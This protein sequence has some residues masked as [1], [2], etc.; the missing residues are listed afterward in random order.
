[1][2]GQQTEAMPEIS[3]E[4]K[5]EID[6]E[7]KIEVIPVNPTEIVNE[8]N[9]STSATEDQTEPTEDIKKKP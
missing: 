6:D 3:T 1:M 9:T 5:V 2:A 8:E 7:D 4:V